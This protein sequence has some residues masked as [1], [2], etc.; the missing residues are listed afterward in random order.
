[1]LEAVKI[2]N[3]LT[4]KTVILDGAMGTELQKKG[5]PGGVCPEYWCLKNP[6]IMG[7]LY[8]AYQ[9]AGSQVVYTCTFGA[10]H[11]KLKQYGIKENSYQINYELA[12]M[13]KQACDKKTL[14]AGDI[15]STG[16]FIE[17]FGPL[18]F[19]EAVDAF[20]E[21]VRGLI[22]GGCD[23]I[24]IE[25]MIDIQEAR[26]AL[27]AVKEIK[28][29]FTIV[30]M[31]YEKDGH[32]LGGTDP[33]TALITLQ[34]LGADAV[35]CNC[36]TGPEKMVEFIA[37][38]KP[39]ATVPLLAKPN[40]GM[41]RLESG[42]TIFEM[43]A[44]TFAS[45][46]RDLVKAGANML[47]G[48]CGTTPEHIRELA[49]ATARTRPSLP[50]RKSIS[51]LSS[52]RGFVLL[53][54]NQ[55]L[56]IV[57]ERI[58][59][60]GK[61]ALQQELIEGKTSI[62]R[63]MALDQE[64]QGANLL[65]VN[66]GQPGID[67]V[68]TIKEIISLL[69]TTTRLPLV[70]D[71]SNVKTIEAALRIYPGR[72]LINSISG[73][74]EKITKLLP[75]AAKYGAMFIL[76][77]LTGGEV[78]QTAQKRQTIIK[79]IFQKAKNFGFTKDD[80]I[81]DC[82]VMAVASNPDA[83]DET[84]KTLHWCTH[85]FK[86]KTNLGLSNVSFGMPGRPWLNATFLAMAQLNGLTMAIAN[87]A[88][89]EMMNV[90]KAGDVLL[91]RDKDALHFIEHFS[92]QG[93]VSSATA[94]GKV[95]TPQ[96]KIAN[97][98]INGDRDN[99]LPFIETALSAGSLA[100]DLVDNIMIP[101]IVQVGDLYERKLF[102]LPQLMAAAE[103]MKKALGYLEPQLKKD[104]IEHKGK[105]LLATVKGDIHDIGKNIVALLLRNYG[106]YVI[107]LGKDVSGEDIIETTQ[108]EKPDVIGLSALMTTTMVNMKDV[109]MLARAK[110]IQKPFMVGGAVLTENYAKSMGAHFAKD[111]VEAVKVAGK[112]I[113][114]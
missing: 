53:S 29:I 69:S 57:G 5:M 105:I 32:T 37:A 94:A 7:N 79:N 45:F 21:Q 27:L 23:L 80:F 22:D 108:K 109:I 58:N 6:Q 43:D 11:F 14:V 30:S 92:A 76:L 62:I 42:K 86:S 101:S 107:D 100:Q 66:V 95:L 9:K 8:T 88:S 99:I 91:A 104:S 49:K 102:F 75:L 47:G 82:L 4:K 18:A 12:R 97:A 81:V 25:T 39:Y 59:P 73:E 65:D 113:K 90:K 51:A 110:G 89:S 67:E 15:G 112:L 34:G 106:Y 98:I 40:A 48:C 41:P 64:I 74:K 46:G 60:T 63:Q 44:K 68:K 2:K 26:A 87:P 28:N 56:V 61:K 17:P 13:A 96:E 78:P 38:M 3:L 54:E 35:G 71:S 111:G 31:T 1:M 33:V 24:V 85:T 52:A 83:A 55:P 103:T 50:R 72:I 77:P 114:K 93:N 20:K 19:E 16:L 70:I 10:N 84:L 36:S